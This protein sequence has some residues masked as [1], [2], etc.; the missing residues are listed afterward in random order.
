MEPSEPTFPA[1]VFALGGETYGVRLAAVR[2]IAPADDLQRVPRAPAVIRGLADLRGRMVTAIDLT[3]IAGVAPP[4]AAGFLMVLAEP[5]DHLALWSPGAIDLRPLERAAL[6]PRPEGEPPEVLE[7]T[8]GG[9][10]SAVSLLSVE[11]VLLWCEQ[12]VLRRYRL[13]G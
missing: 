8:V 3:A 2:E 13:A 5:R 12:E 9:G 1:L 11:R 10:A 7:G 6:R 4:A